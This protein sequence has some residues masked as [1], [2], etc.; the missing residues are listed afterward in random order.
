M[1]GGEKEGRKEGPR[2]L[3]ALA[4][5]VQLYVAMYLS[6]G[7]EEGEQAEMRGGG[8]RLFGVVCNW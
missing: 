8:R 2:M 7:A 6:A 3:S 5:E 4:P 1:V